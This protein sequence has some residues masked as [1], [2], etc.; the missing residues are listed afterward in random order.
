MTAN[1]PQAAVITPRGR[2]AV[3]T[4]SINGPTSIWEKLPFVSAVSFSPVDQPLGRI[5]FGLWHGEKVVLTRVGET[6]WELHCHGGSAAIARIQSDLEQIDCRIQSWQEMVGQN[7][8]LLE[9]EF[10]IATT[11]AVT[12]KTT[13]FLLRHSALQLL[14][15]L[16]DW[17]QRLQNSPTNT[18][19]IANECRQILSWQGFGRRLIQPALV[20]LAGAPNVGKS[21]LLNRLAGYERAIVQNQPG[22]TRDVVGVDIVLEGFPITL[23]DTAGLRVTED[24]LES[25]GISRA[26]DV[27]QKADLILHLVDVSS[28]PSEEEARFATHYPDAVTILHKCD[29]PLH[30]GRTSSSGFL[31]SSLTGAGIDP[32]IASIMSRLIPAYPSSDDLF[33]VTDRQT[34]LLEQIESALEH[35]HASKAERLIERLIHG[36]SPDS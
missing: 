36:E 17:Q 8:S 21:S 33:P 18:T 1:S 13:E 16:Q 31:V 22:T 28:A 29:T 20:V 24:Q 25:M 35:A 6:E 27:L 4:W 23:T 34:R 7:Q 30:A 10:Q 12:W 15:R 2:G 5:L 26:Q 32:L 3:A 14:Q 9:S 11:Q 19:P